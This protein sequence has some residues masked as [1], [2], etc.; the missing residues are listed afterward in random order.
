MGFPQKRP[1]CQLTSQKREELA[2]KA[3]SLDER[4]STVK[5]AKA[6]LAVADGCSFAEAG[7]QVGMSGDGV[8]QLVERF[9][10][11]GM[12]ALSI[13]PGRGLKPTYT[14]Q[15]HAQILQEIQRRPTWEVDQCTVWSLLLLQR[16]LHAK[17][18]GDISPR[19]IRR[20]L[21]AHGWKYQPTTRIWLHVDPGE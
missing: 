20:V 4:V 8:S 15:E 6:L 19:T 21:Q 7:R 2:K 5:R 18:L 12:P 13:A 10:H 14:S 9:H 11:R 16:S 17:G 3:T 1:L